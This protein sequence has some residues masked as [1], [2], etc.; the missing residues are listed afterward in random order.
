MPSNSSLA[1]LSYL[2]QKDFATDSI[3][4]LKW[5]QIAQ[6]TI[7]ENEV[8][9]TQLLVEKQNLIDQLDNLQLEM[10]NLANSNLSLI[11]KVK[12]FHRLI[13]ELE[14]KEQQNQELNKT[15]QLLETKLN[16]LIIRQT[17]AEIENAKNQ[18]NI[19]NLKETIQQKEELITNL[20]E[21][22]KELHK[23]QQ[24]SRQSKQDLEKQMSNLFSSQSQ[25]QIQISKQQGQIDYWKKKNQQL[26]TY[27]AELLIELQTNQEKARELET[28]IKDIPAGRIITLTSELEQNQGKL[29]DLESESDQ[30][31]QIIA[32]LREKLIQSQ[33]FIVRLGKKTKE[34][35]ATSAQEYQKLADELTT[36]SQQFQTELS[37]KERL[38]VA[39]EK[40]K[41]KINR[42]YLDLV[43]KTQSESKKP[44]IP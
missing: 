20:R 4:L 16:Q 6:T 13:S 9:I 11:E 23:K 22:L 5:L 43:N 28:L 32:Q 38:L 34:W 21:K 18:Q 42:N 41:E 29:N 19:E 3:Q 2:H 33:N 40:E 44:S 10:N 17:K 1:R 25:K 8:T 7:E 37:E 27:Q 31:E 14:F 26:E 35:N 24:Q 15:N 36:I 12:E 39:A 30:K